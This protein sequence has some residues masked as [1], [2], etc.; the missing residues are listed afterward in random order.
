[1]VYDGWF[2]TTDCTDDTDVKNLI[3]ARLCVHLPF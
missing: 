1:L 2:L 3:S